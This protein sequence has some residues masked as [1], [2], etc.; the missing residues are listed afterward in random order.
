MGC[1]RDNGTS[2]GADLALISDGNGDD[3]PERS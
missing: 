1:C 3:P 2:P